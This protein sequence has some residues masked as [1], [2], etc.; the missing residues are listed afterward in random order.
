MPLPDADRII[1]IAALGEGRHIRQIGAALRRADTGACRKQSGFYRRQRRCSSE[2][3]H[4]PGWLPDNRFG[5]G[6][7][8]RLIGYMGHLDAGHLLEHSSPAR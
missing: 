7:D 8:P 3:K 1:R 6:R 2:S 4:P 5:Q